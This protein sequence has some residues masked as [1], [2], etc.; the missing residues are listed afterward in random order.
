MSY[1]YVL[2]AVIGISLQ[3]SSFKLYQLRTVTA[4][5]TAAA[6]SEK[7]FYFALLRGGFSLLI[8]SIL[9]LATGTGLAVPPGVSVFAAAG[10]VGLGIFISLAGI[11]A[12][13]RGTMATYTLF[14]ML[15]GMMLPFLVG[16]FFWG[17]PPSPWRIAG[18]ILLAVSLYAP[19]MD[20][21]KSKNTVVFFF[22]CFLI[23]MCNGSI[24]ILSK[25]HQMESEPVRVG[26]IN[27]I[28]LSDMLTG[29]INAVLWL[30]F[31]SLRRGRGGDGERK[32]TPRAVGANLGIIAMY[33]MVSGLAYMLLLR[34]AVTL[35]ASVL[36]PMVTGGAIITTAIAGY[37]FFREKPGK[38]S[39]VGIAIAVF[40]TLLFMVG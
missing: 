31:R 9:L 30:I 25:Y 12:L 10:L 35:D 39:T 7:C 32:D 36:F 28:L 17:E 27:F 14:M 6:A 21:K 23:F 34:A 13:S 2:L 5:M 18:L 3:F 40:A 37:L 29:P 19:V 20:S 24:S 33:A 15:G 11:M 26:E 1:L 22:L 16:V 4:S 38:F 8:F